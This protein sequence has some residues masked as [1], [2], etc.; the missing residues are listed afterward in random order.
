MLQMSSKVI[1]ITNINDYESFKK[2]YRRGI[3]FYG[4][5]WCEAC[6]EIMPLYTRIANKYYKRIAMAHCDIDVCKLDFSKIPV[7]VSHRKGKEIDNMLGGNKDALRKFIKDAIEFEAKPKGLTPV[8]HH[9]PETK[10]RDAHYLQ[11]NKSDLRQHMHNKL[12]QNRPLMHHESEQNK[13]SMYMDMHS[14]LQDKKLS[15]GN[16]R[17][18]HSNTKRIGP[19]E[20]KVQSHDLD[21]LNEINSRIKGSGNREIK[22]PASRMR[23]QHIMEDLEDTEEEEELYDRKENNLKRLLMNDLDDVDVEEQTPIKTININD[24]VKTGSAY[25]N[26]SNFGGFT[27]AEVYQNSKAK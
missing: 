12:Q 22:M 1:E 18:I 6:N 27:V 25:G 14:E 24:M 21:L 19:S 17:A 8:S 5:K 13:S 15:T 26:R 7:F 10:S 23:A 2:N 16:I 4:A 11:D 9:E 20:N 3:I